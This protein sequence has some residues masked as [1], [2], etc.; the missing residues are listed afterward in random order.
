M[1]DAKAIFEVASRLQRTIDKLGVGRPSPK[2]II[3]KLED[4][5]EL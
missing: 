1:A 2:D 4:F 3:P 5:V